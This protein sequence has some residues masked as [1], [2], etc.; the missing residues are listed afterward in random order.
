MP[1]FQGIELGARAMRAF[2][3]GLEVTGHN[4]ANV[5]TPGFSR[6]RVHFANTPEYAFNPNIRI[7]TG[8]IVQH[9]QRVRDMM[10]EQRINTN[11]GEFARLDT[12]R[13]QLQGIEG[14]LLEP[15]EQGISARLNA[16]FNAFDELATRPDSMAARQSVLQAASALVSAIRSVHNNWQNLNN[17]I[18]LRMTQTI[19]EAN[20][21]AAQ[22]GRLNEQIRAA[23]SNGAEASDL[24]DQRDRLMTRLSEL[25]GARAHYTGDG[26]I[27]VF[28]DGHTLV[29]DGA[30]FP[31]PNTIDVPNRDLDS[32]P[33]DIRIQGGQLRGLMDAAA[34]LQDFMSRLNLFTNTLITQ[35]NALHQTGYGLDNNTGYLFF[36]GTDASNIALHSDV[37][38]PQRIAASGLAN[39]PGNNGVA[40]AILNLRNQP[41]AVLGGMSL[42]QYYRDLVGRIGNDAQVSRNR[43]ESQQLTLEHLHQIRES[44]SGVSLDEEAANLVKYQ[45]SYQAAAKVISV[46]DGLIQDVLQIVR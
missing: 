18:Q 2:Q 41:Q 10:L 6:R 33:V 23:H 30:S 5:N 20:D 36:D 35:V 42:P 3:I 19:S 40:Q 26:G 46:F 8:V 4:V 12:L 15:G 37:S 21:I 34:N 27:M 7:G 14:A 45:R 31:L 39:T 38:D 43:A 9:V 22:L 32:T 28:V 44:V 11:T 29:Q 16:F 1:S 17:Q 13:Q 24:L 25:V